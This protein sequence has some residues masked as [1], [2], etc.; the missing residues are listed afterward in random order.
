MVFVLLRCVVLCCAVL[1]CAVLC[2]AV[3]CCAAL[4]CA[5][6]CCAVVCCVVLCCGVQRGRA[7]LQVGAGEE[8]VGSA[9]LL[10][11]IANAHVG[12]VVKSAYIAL[13]RAVGLGFNIADEASIWV[14][15]EC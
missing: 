1:C 7:Q 12:I 14:G 5:V 10:A 6:L 8:E 2:C 3:L 13:P 11:H 4:C 15:R 9:S